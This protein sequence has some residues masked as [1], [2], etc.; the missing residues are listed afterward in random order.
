MDGWFVNYKALSEVARSARVEAD[1]AER[2]EFLLCSRISGHP[3]WG[4]LRTR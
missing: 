3:V 4:T 1:V 2:S